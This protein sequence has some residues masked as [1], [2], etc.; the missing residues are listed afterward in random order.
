MRELAHAV[1]L[2]EAAE[3][4]LHQALTNGGPRMFGVTYEVRQAQA[5]LQD[6][7]RFLARADVSLADR[8]PRPSTHEGS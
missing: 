2:I 3:D 8:V 6:A 7:R 5:R 4:R 1:E